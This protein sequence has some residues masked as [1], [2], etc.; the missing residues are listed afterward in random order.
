[1]PVVIVAYSGGY[2]PASAAIS[3]GGANDRI[4]G[5][6]LLDAL[7]GETDTFADWI[8]KRHG[9]SFSSAPIRARRWLR[10][11]LCNSGSRRNR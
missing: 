11:L 10:T 4:A 9:Q 6:I 3:V 5:V 2:M 1:M 8:A 7:Y